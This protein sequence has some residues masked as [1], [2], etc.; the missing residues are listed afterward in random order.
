MRLLVLAAM[1]A[2]SPA[3]QA[4]LYKCVDAKGRTHYTDKPLADCRGA[5]PSEIKPP[6]APPRQA[7]RPDAAKAAKAAEKKKREAKAKKPSERE[8]LQ[9]AALC[10]GWKEEE[11]W[12]VRSKDEH[13]DARLGQVRQA[14]RQ[15]R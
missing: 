14:L 10:R 13:R 12:L 5:T 11:A 4:Q 3:A 7:A 2:V 9:L 6:P 15:C 8:R 1:L